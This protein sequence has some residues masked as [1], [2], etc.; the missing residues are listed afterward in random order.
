MPLYSY[1][2]IDRSCKRQK[3]VLLAPDEEALLERLHNLQIKVICCS[4]CRQ[5]RFYL[6]ASDKEEILAFFMH[7]DGQTRCGWSLLEALRSFLDI[8]RNAPLR[9]ALARI[10]ERL[11]AG[12]SLGTAFSSERSIFSPIAV[13][14]LQA[15]EATGHVH[16]VLPALIE[17]LQLADQATYKWRQATQQPLLTLGFSAG[18]AFL[19]AHLLSSQVKGLSDLSRD[20]M[21]LFSALLIKAFDCVDFSSFAIF[22][23]G[24]IFMIFG[25]WIRPS[26]RLILHQ[27]AFKMPFVKHVLQRVSTWQFSVALSLLLKAKVDLLRAF[28]FATRAV[29]NLYARQI[30]QSCDADIRAGKTVAQAIEEGSNKC[31]SSGF[32]SALKVGERANT[33]Q[34]VLEI[35]NTNWH[36]ELQL[37]IQRAS[38]R[39][40]SCITGLAGMLLM[41]LLLGFFYP[42][43]HYIGQVD[44]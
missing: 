40:S 32:I 34:P 4:L 35:F 43:Y 28:P 38:V 13:G 12:E 37:F 5:R 14:L 10:T 18:A 24:V 20:S 8:T 41:G 44:F 21:P 31:I 6:N 17:H 3:G 11:E 33:L 36:R 42:I 2:G 16:T 30:L 1:R 26:G 22:A 9:A 29:G 19:S 23:G 39:F 27:L 15:A 25:M 7:I